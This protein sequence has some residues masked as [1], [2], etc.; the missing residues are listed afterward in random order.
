MSTNVAMLADIPVFSL[1][2]HAERETLAQIMDCEHVAAGKVIFDMGDVGDCLYILR[3]GH[4]HIYVENTT[5]EKIVLGEFE[6]GEVFGEI[7]LLDGGPRTATAIAM[8]DSEL[9]VLTRD[10]LQSLITE[11]PHAAI[12]LL[13]MVGRRLR[14]TDELLRSHVSR[15]ANVEE[16]ERMTFGERVADKVASFGGSWGFIFLFGTILFGWMLANA[17][18]LNH[19]PWDPYPFIL[20]NLGLSTLAALQ[21]PVIMMSQNRQST[22]DRIKSDLDYEV[23]MKAELEVAHLHNKIDKIYER[24]QEHWA[25]ADKEKK[26]GM[27][28]PQTGN[29]SN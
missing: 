19:R 24:I 25:Q 28:G 3:S 8:E 15:N 6:P 18:W 21:A 26:S 7:S 1:L 29:D 9:F 4:V 23:N 2:D 13:T 11:H 27:I 17:A 10:D 22:K 5:G 20:L 14:T 16:D 12:D